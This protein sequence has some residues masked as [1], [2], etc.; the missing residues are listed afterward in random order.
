[1]K[2]K[3][4]KKVRRRF[5]IM[6]LPKGYV[7]SSDGYHYNYNLYK[8]VDADSEYNNVV[9][10][11]LN[12][13]EPLHGVQYSLPDLIFETDKE[14]IEYLQNCIIKI[15]QNEGFRNR[16]QRIINNSAEKVWWIKK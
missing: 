1:M 7:A 3:L 5:S 15:L 4:L 11:Q 9:Y 6:H 12:H 14:C 2:V 10:V 16:K 13:K 8:L